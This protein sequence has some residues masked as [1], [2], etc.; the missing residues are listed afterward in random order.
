M[1]GE[2]VEGES[3]PLGVGREVFHVRS[4]TSRKPGAWLLLWPAG[5]NELA[6]LVNTATNSKANNAE[7]TLDRRALV[8]NLRALRTIKPHEDILAAYGATYTRS[9]LQRPAQADKPLFGMHTCERCGARV[10][11]LKRHEA[12]FGPCRTQRAN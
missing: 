3:P 1:S 7:L 11:S 12:A 4:P 9:L 2:V 5:C 8:V 10:K 6:N